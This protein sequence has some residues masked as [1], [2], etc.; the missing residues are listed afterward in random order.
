MYDTLDYVQF[1]VIKVMENKHDDVIK[2]YPIDHLVF[3]Y[4]PD[5]G[6][7]FSG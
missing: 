3:S 6:T 5:A 4:R 2:Q 7:C 1:I